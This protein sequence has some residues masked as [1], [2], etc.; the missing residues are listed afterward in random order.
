ML[1]VENPSLLLLLVVVQ[2]FEINGL[3][4]LFYTVSAFA[5]EKK[6]TTYNL[7]KTQPFAHTAYKLVSTFTGTTMAPPRW[8][9]VYI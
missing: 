6:K 8:T 5:K 2:P 3:V 9:E 7:Y 1:V 4:Q